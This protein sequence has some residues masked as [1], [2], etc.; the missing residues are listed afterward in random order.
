MRLRHI[1]FLACLIACTALAQGQNDTLRVMTFNLHAGHDASLQQIGEFIRHYQP[2]FVALQE[3]DKNTH[4]SNCPHQNNR[5][6]I[7]ELAY[8]SGMQGLF[9]P[10]SSLAE[11]ITASVCSHDISLSMCTTSSCRIPMT[12]WSNEAC[13][14]ALL[15]SPT[16]IPSCL[17]ALI[18][19]PSTASAE[20]PKLNSY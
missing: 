11:A 5:D 9:S 14:R 6:F 17:H 8:Y 2:D 16:V 7:T 13:L 3:V 1:I 15:S 20:L 10:L 19:R 4:R 18:S 12:A